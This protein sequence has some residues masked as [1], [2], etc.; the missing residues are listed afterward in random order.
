LAFSGRKPTKPIALWLLAGLATEGA[1][2]EEIDQH[3]EKRIWSK[4]Q[5]AGLILEDCMIL[6]RRGVAQM[7][8][9]GVAKLPGIS[10]TPYLIAG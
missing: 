4:P 9:P 6:S 3:L 2:A 1:L 7:R 5:Q 8:I 10:L